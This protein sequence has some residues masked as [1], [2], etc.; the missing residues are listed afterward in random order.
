[1][2]LFCPFV[3]LQSWQVKIN[4]TAD[5]WLGHPQDLHSMALAECVE[6]E[7]GMKP[8]WIRE[9][10]SI[11]SIPFLEQECMSIFF[12]ISSDQAGTQKSSFVHISVLKVV[13]S[14]FC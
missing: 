4:Q 2:L 8:L 13:V 5:W 1:M 14:F 11:P 10:G 6:E 9:G 7:W 3:R 12:V